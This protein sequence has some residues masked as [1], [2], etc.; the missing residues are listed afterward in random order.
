MKTS[1]LSQLPVAPAWST[2][3]G[4]ESDVVL[5]A[6]TRLSR[7]LSGYPYPPGASP[8]DLEASTQAVLEAARGELSPEPFGADSLELNPAGF[9]SRELHFL[10]ERSLSDGAS[11]TRIMVTPDERLSLVVG[12]IDHLR[13][14]T[15]APG[16]AL[17]SALELAR[18]VDQKLEARL[19][20]AVAMD[21]GYLSSEITNLGTGL[22]ASVLVHVPVLAQL[23][24]LESMSASMENSGYELLPYFPDDGF[25]AGGAALCL[26][27]NRR[28]LGSDEEAIVGKLED[29]TSKLVHYERVARDELRAAQGEEIAD[30]ANRALG[31]L[32]FARSLSAVEARS[33]VSHLRL[34]I[35][36]G[37]VSG[38]AV[39]T[40][41]SLLLINQESHLERNRPSEGVGEIDV[42][43]ARVFRDILD[44]GHA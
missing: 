21:W 25:G 15:I 31:V 18:S 30:S 41:T 23:D 43:R 1:E 6:R 2:R 28:G 4:A 7:N 22:R 14:V 16:L 37:L 40:V 32:R 19:N 11:P 34:G 36:A 10:A 33:L 38:V 17:R 26:L 35:V 39:E 12:A 3:A 29:Y 20:Y 44:A 13:I 8:S 5:A 24:R 42:V 9:S 27:R